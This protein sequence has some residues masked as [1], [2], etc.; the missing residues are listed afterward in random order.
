M[1]LSCSPRKHEKQV[2]FSLRVGFP[3]HP[4]FEARRDG[5]TGQYYDP[6]WGRRGAPFLVG[7]C[8]PYGGMGVS[9]PIICL[10]RISDSWKIIQNIWRSWGHA[11]MPPPLWHPQ[12]RWWCITGNLSRAIPVRLCPSECKVVQEGGTNI[13]KKAFFCRAKKSAVLP[14]LQPRVHKHR[15]EIHLM[16]IFSFI[17]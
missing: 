14:Q 1:N 17:W 2:L 8:N 3:Y 5:L 12:L 15:S 10:L 6:N 7:G 13:L 9:T 16:V 11:S 4:L